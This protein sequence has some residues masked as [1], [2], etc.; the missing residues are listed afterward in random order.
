VD[1]HQRGFTL[2]ELLIV[3]AIIGVLVGLVAP[4]VGRARDIAR[5]V[6]CQT[7]LHAVAIGVRMYLDESNDVM[8]VAAQMPSQQLNDDPRIAD[9]LSPYLPSADVLECPADTDKRFFETEGSSYE[10]HSMLGGKRVSESFLTRHWGEQ[11]TPVMNDYEPFHGPAGE[12]G[13]ANYLFADGHVGD[14]E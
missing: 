12:S 2:I 14:L 8:P 3:I 1:A 9:V 10:Y 4:S 11:Y 6:A 13:A 7:K 5:A